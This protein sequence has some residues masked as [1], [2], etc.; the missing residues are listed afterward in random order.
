[1]KN[2]NI[3]HPKAIIAKKERF[4]IIARLKKE[5]FCIIA[6]LKKER[7]CPKEFV[8]EDV[9]LEDEGAKVKGII[10]RIDEIY[11]NNLNKFDF[12]LYQAARKSML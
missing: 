5:R 6:R 11:G 4:C 12:D 7:F 1:M 9:S 8:E 3:S 2:E 10:A